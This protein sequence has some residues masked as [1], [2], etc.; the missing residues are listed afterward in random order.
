MKF[1]CIKKK[2]ESHP[3]IQDV[4]DWGPN[5]QTHKLQWSIKSQIKHIENYSFGSSVSNMV[6]S[7][8]TQNTPLKIK[9]NL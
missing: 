1:Y 9:R 6:S 4:F 5:N 8:G 3:S 7:A 2:E